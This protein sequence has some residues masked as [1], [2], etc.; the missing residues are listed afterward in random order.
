MK[1]L[2]IWIAAL[3]VTIGLSTVASAKVDTLQKDYRAEMARVQYAKRVHQ[4]K[5]IV[6]QH[7]QK[8][9]SLRKQYTRMCGERYATRPQS[10]ATKGAFYRKAMMQS[11]YRH[12]CPYRHDMPERNTDQGMASQAPCLRHEKTS[13]DCCK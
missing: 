1:V 11:Q 7:P 9:A 6:L 5:L 4:Q 10:L 13:G 12:D 2:G 3:A 8:M